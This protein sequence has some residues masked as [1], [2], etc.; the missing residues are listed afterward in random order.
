MAALIICPGSVVFSVVYR[1]TYERMS[2][3]RRVPDEIRKQAMMLNPS[4]RPGLT[5]R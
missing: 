3:G 2:I 1:C 4:P 5:E